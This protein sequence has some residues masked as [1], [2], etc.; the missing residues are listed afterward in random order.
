MS[1]IKQSWTKRCWTW[2]VRVEHSWGLF[3]FAVSIMVAFGT[4]IWM[5]LSSAQGPHIVVA[6][7]LAYAAT[8]A[9]LKLTPWHSSTERRVAS[10]PTPEQSDRQRPTYTAPNGITRPIATYDELQLQKVIRG[11][12][13]LLQD[14]PRAPDSPWI[15]GF[16]FEDCIVLGPA[17]I[18]ITDQLIIECVFG[19]EDEDIG[20]I[21][22]KMPKNQ[23]R[24]GAIGFRRTVFKNCFF[25]GIGVAGSRDALDS[26]KN[27]VL[28]L[29]QFKKK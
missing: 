3:S 7:L 28:N 4:S 25:Q 23:K 17:V 18:A 29:D 9:S 20:T 8:M 24:I 19:I 16:T 13:L 10:R 12:A 15:E 14:I 26:L 6:F 21:L 22:W 5:Y 27:G 2:F 1:Q 11:R